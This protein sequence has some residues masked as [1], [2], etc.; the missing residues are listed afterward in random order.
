[1][2]EEDRF[3]IACAQ[4]LQKE[5]SV[6]SVQWTVLPSSAGMTPERL[7]ERYL[8]HIR[9]YTLGLIRPSR[10]P[11]GISFRL[12]GAGVD[13]L[14]FQGPSRG[15]DGSLTLAIC[16]GVLVERGS[17]DRGELTFGCEEV[18]GGTRV[19][20]RLSNY[21]PLLLGAAPGRWRKGLYRFT[22]AAIHRLVTVRFLVR[23]QREAAGRHIC[24][25][26]VR[27]PEVEGEP[28]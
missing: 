28:I 23:L 5:S 7:L 26:V 12:T 9:R 27:I 20:L 11:E 6:L 17:C 24:C 8:D 4:V 2:A 1:M 18:S 10:T 16:G 19:A 25:R 22:Q 21:C 13:L 15:A 14:A 3:E